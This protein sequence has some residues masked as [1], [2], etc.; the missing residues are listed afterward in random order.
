M[1][2]LLPSFIFKLSTEGS[3][4]EIA[5]LY[6]SFFT[7]LQMDE[8]VQEINEIISKKLYNRIPFLCKMIKIIIFMS[9]SSFQS[10]IK[11]LFLQ[12][13]HYLD[14]IGRK[15]DGRR[16]AGGGF[17]EG[18]RKKGAGNKEEKRKT[19]GGWLNEGERD[20]RKEEESWPRFGGLAEGGRRMEG[21]EMEEGRRDLGKGLIIFKKVI[22]GRGIEMLKSDGFR[23]QKLVDI[24]GFK[25]EQNMGRIEKNVLL[26]SHLVSG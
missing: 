1:K 25:S 18:R 17:D 26:E 15:E 7:S 3:Y 6:L 16:T 22:Y 23:G 9:R 24:G 5:N 13:D 19:V 21:R 2:K 4:K 10:Q 8:R 20:V 14:K 11:S 12:I